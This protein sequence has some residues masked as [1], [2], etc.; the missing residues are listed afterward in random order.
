M[1]KKILLNIYSLTLLPLT[2]NYNVYNSNNFNRISGNNFSF[3]YEV[4]TTR[5]N[6]NYPFSKIGDCQIIDNISNFEVSYN[7]NEIDYKNILCNQVFQNK[8]LKEY[9]KEI[10]YFIENLNFVNNDNKLSFVVKSG[11]SNT[12]RIEVDGEINKFGYYL[13]TI[14]TNKIEFKKMS[15]NFQ[16]NEKEFNFELDYYLIDNVYSKVNF[17]ETLSELD[18]F[19]NKYGL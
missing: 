9:K 1:K 16:I 19:M 13:I 14:N 10:L 18:I 2:N 3:I 11:Y 7:V 5:T 6:T 15:V 4:E 8:E 17:F 12:I